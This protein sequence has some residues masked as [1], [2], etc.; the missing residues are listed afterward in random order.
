MPENT[1]NLSSANGSD[2]ICFTFS[3]NKGEPQKSLSKV[4]SGGEMSRF[5]LAVKT[6]LMCYKLD[7]VLPCR[8][9]INA[10]RKPHNFVNFSFFVQPFNFRNSFTAFFYL[11]YKKL[12]V[13]RGTYLRKM[14]YRKYLRFVGYLYKLFRNSKI[15]KY[16]RRQVLCSV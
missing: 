8:R 14:R 16:P 11:I 6:C 2:E 5:M 4:I 10:A 15:L 12:R 7:S 3:A 1:A 13:T 9:G